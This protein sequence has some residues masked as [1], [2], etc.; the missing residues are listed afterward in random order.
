MKLIELIDEFKEASGRIDLDDLTI[1]KHLNRGSR[2]LDRRS[3][4][5]K[6][7]SRAHASLDP[8]GY[9]LTTDPD[10]RSIKSVWASTATKRWQLGQT[11]L[12]DMRGWY[13]E[14]PHTVAPGAIQAYCLTSVTL[15]PGGPV[16]GANPSANFF[17]QWSGDLLFNNAAGYKGMIVWPVAEEVTV[18]EVIGNYYTPALKAEPGYDINWWSMNHPEL[19]IQAALITLDANYRNTAGAKDLYA[20]IDNELLEIY[21]DDIEEDTYQ[22]SAMGGSQ[23]GLYRGNGTDLV[24]QRRSGQD[25]W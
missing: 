6:I 7:E 14:S 11:S 20:F 13:N 15:G 12:A 18:I 3:K 10:L 4:R 19:L 1:T 8:L 25:Y 16:D 23:Y 21:H 5:E 2:L 17:V 9:I 22:S 24:Q